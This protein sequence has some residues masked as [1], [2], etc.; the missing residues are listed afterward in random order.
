LARPIPFVR[1][2][3]FELNLPPPN[4]LVPQRFNRMP[5]SKLRSP[6]LASLLRRRRLAAI[7]STAAI[8]QTML[9]RA[10]LPGWPCPL[11]HTLGLP[12]PGCGLT[13]AAVVLL[14]GDWRAAL[15]LH[16]Y[17]PVLVLTLSLFAC[18]ALLPARARDAL[19]LRIAAF[20]RRTGLSAVLAVGLIVYW[21]A[22]LALAPAT[23]LRLAR[24]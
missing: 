4:E 11:A 10:G 15:T 22:R 16:L 12:C 3:D 7:I 13:R 23:M 5:D 1:G 20:E 2:A 18:A 24:G 19:V 14:G 8:L 6:V 21:L 9:V 17:A